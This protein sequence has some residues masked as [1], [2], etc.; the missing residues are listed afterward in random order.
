MT[1]IPK[2]TWLTQLLPSPYFSCDF[3]WL[4]FGGPSR[5]QSLSLLPTSPPAQNG[6]SRPHSP[7]VEGTPLSHTSPWAE[8][9]CVAVE[10]RTYYRL[11]QRQYYLSKRNLGTK[12]FGHHVFYVGQ[13]RYDHLKYKLGEVHTEG[14]EKNCGSAL[15]SGPFNAYNFLFLSVFPKKEFFQRFVWSVPVDDFLSCMDGSVQLVV[16]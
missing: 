2:N 6:R 12:P 5:F 14:R 8:W 7:A 9:T 16:G 13:G 1:D 15:T 10:K 4:T 3:C 11:Y